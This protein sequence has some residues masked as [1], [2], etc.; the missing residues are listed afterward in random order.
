M[1]VVGERKSENEKAKIKNQRI[2]AKKP[3]DLCNQLAFV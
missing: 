2:K 3:V 1:Q